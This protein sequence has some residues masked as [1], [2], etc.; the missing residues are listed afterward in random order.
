MRASGF[1]TTDVVTLHPDT[2]VKAAAATLA[3]RGIASA[4]VVL[5]DGTLVGVV[6]E[7]D[8]LARDVPPDPL[9]RLARVEPDRSPPPR[10][11]AD[12][13]TRD[14]LTLPPDADAAQFLAYMVRD[15]IL[16]VPVLAEDR[17][18]GVVS[19]RDLLRLLARPDEEIAG[20]VEA[21]LAEAL[22]RERWRARVEDGIARLT[23]PAP[24]AQQ[25]V[26][27][28]VAQSVPGVVRVG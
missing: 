7:L 2:S 9:A 10:V 24:D 4:P 12:V 17:V 21:A 3:G 11:V 6:S 8:L 18:V 27:A 19:R 5:D 14:V 28:R 26:A 16:C 1:M 23:S 22:P 25:D 15:R 20:D 13:M